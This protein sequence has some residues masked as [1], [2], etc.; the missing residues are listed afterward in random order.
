MSE[1]IIEPNKVVA[2][3]YRIIDDRGN[4]TEQ[5][6]ILVEYMHG[7]SQNMFE[8]VKQA[9]VGKKPGIPWKWC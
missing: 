5:S 7:V 2:M 1:E 3:T 8:K 9:L 6:D 4:V